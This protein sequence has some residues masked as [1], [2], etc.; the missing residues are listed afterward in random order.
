MFCHMFFF[1]LMTS[2]NYASV[3][4]SAL[5]TGKS[6]QSHLIQCLLI[7]CLKQINARLD[8][9]ASHKV[10]F[11]LFQAFVAYCCRQNNAVK[12]KVSIWIIPTNLCSLLWHKA[13]RLPFYSTMFNWKWGPYSVCFPFSITHSLNT[14]VSCI[15]LRPEKEE[16]PFA[17]ILMKWAV[18]W[19]RSDSVSSFQ[20]LRD[21]GTTRLFLSLLLLVSDLESGCIK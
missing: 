13:Q 5:V 15:L 1:L 20:C 16:K 10:I 11:I 19:M 8:S 7:L 4:A 14:F 3:T 2:M 21:S 12:N 6:K 18:S 17:S 9:K